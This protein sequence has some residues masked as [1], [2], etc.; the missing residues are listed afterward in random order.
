MP[1][2]P[3]GTPTRETIDVQ[4]MI[5]VIDNTTNSATSAEMAAID[6]FNERLAKAGRW[7]FAGGLAS[8]TA[9]VVVDG[10]DEEASRVSGP[11]LDSIDYV[12]GFWIVEVEDLEAA[13]SIAAEASKCCNRRVEL[14]PFL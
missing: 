10:R 8:P 5:S 2:R 9:A 4:Y 1:P 12:S 6:E 7:V 3:C 11:F 14:R 13:I